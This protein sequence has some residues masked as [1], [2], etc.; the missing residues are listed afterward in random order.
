MN[1]LAP[2]PAPRRTG[3]R[4]QARRSRRT[5][6]STWTMPLRSWRLSLVLLV[7]LAFGSVLM[8]AEAKAQDQLEPELRSL[9]TSELATF[10]EAV[11][12]AMIRGNA[13]GEEAA[14]RGLHP[15]VVALSFRVRDSYHRPDAERLN[16][17]A[18]ELAE[19][20][21]LPRS[22]S[23]SAPLRFSLGPPRP[24]QDDWYRVYVT[25]STRPNEESRI[26]LSSV[27]QVFV[28]R[29]PGGWSGA[30]HRF[31]GTR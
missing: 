18:Q 21:S 29:V 26:A 3:H 13:L 22:A 2:N 27:A 14:A 23:E 11:V 20:W 9:S 5:R 1:R 25:V 4:R 28:K 19:R 6:G 7:V 10:Y 8:A 12:D 31:P 15:G 24:Y 30:A 17:A 16:E